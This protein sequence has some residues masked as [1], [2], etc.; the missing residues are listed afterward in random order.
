MIKNAGIT[1][2][3]GEI[4]A[5]VWEQEFGDFSAVAVYIQRLRKKIEKDYHNP[6]YLRTIHGKGYRFEENVLI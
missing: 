1:F 6:V 3:P 5:S 4:Y 2:S